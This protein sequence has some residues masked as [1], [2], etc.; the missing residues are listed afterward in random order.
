MLTLHGSGIFKATL[1]KDRLTALCNVPLIIA[2][3]CLKVK[4]LQR[5]PQIF[6]EP[7]NF[8]NISQMFL[9]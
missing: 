2:Y 4:F 8:R 5:N 9:L 6:G 1:P 7:Q 3:I